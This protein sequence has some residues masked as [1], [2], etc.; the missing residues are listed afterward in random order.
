MLHNDYGI[1][2]NYVDSSMY[3]CLIDHLTYLT[4]TH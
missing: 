2:L 1:K 3:K 4:N